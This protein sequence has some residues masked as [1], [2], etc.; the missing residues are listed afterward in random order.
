MR[1]CSIATTADLARVRVLVRR[2]A[3]HAP[4]CPVT[5]LYAEDADLPDV[6]GAEVL[7][8]DALGVESS[9][10]RRWRLTRDLPGF[11]E[12][13]K[14]R[15]LAR[16]LDAGGPLVL[17]DPARVPVGRVEAPGVPGLGLVPRLGEAV[18]LDGLEPSEASIV[19]AGV[20]DTGVVLAGPDAREGLDWWAS[21]VATDAA[22]PWLDLAPGLF[23]VTA[24]LLTP[25]GWD[26]SAARI[27]DRR[28]ERSGDAVHLAG[29]PVALLDLAGFDPARPWLLDARRTRDVRTLVSRDPVLREVLLEYA[30]ELDAAGEP[31]GTAAACSGVDDV[32]VDPVVQALA[33]DEVRAASKG[34]GSG[35]DLGDGGTPLRDWL[36]EPET[37]PGGMANL[38]RYLA[39]FYRRRPDLHFAYPGVRAGDVTG[40]LD[41]AELVGIDS[42]G[43]PRWV[44]EA[45]NRLIGRGDGAAPAPPSPVTL[46]PGVEVVG[47]LS[48]DLGIGQAAR[49]LVAGLEHAGVPVSTRTWT[50]T[51]SRLG[52]PWE[53]RAP[54][55]GTRH[56]TVV[57]C[58]NAD[59]LPTFLNEDAGPGFSEGRRVIGF[60]FWELDDFPP[61][62]RPALEPLDEIWVTS[63][64][65]ADVLRAATD[66][67]VHVLPLPVHSPERSDV[68]VPEL[69]D[70]EVFTF[71]FVF[72]YLSV[73]QRKNPLGLVAA[74]VE[75]FPEPG[76]ARLVIK[77]INRAMRPEHA[78][79]LAHVIAD[80]PDVVVI[81]RYLS[82]AELDALMWR[83]D[84][85]VS[86]HRSE[87]FGFTMA[88]EMAIGKPVIATG[89]SGNM[90][91][92]TPAN[93][94]PLKYTM[95]AV[96]PDADPY[97]EGSS[98]AEP[99][100]AHAVRVMR[101]IH[102]DGELRERLGAAA[103]ATIAE[104]HS[105]EALAAEAVRRLGDVDGTPADDPGQPASPRSWLRRARRSVG[106]DRG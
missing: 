73:F 89:Y 5:V 30:A 83:A 40:F 105:V 69:G 62:L 95:V 2:L 55:P 38:G 45:G 67:P 102:E 100:R 72:D 34:R 32:V 65:T 53:D 27:R 11:V 58:I 106:P 18:P 36:A 41:W 46:V 14:P 77:T 13:L 91:F 94:R 20:V 68:Q 90:E 12:T 52:V 26:V 64:F 22:T 39:E 10:L 25:A 37:G 93:S 70:S 24:A 50:R 76:A 28:L 15:L 6:E 56:D 61:G 42:D 88:E 84:C 99:R 29:K 101:R 75:A 19:R 17:L 74:F 33:V 71:L 82:R 59:M 57:L 48:A 92:M 35:L 66:K 78:E 9:E 54:Q 7:R 4:G 103:A 86:L 63:G 81:D 104:R 87:G 80:R 8:L 47:F 60:W 43:I 98:W 16:L 31:A 1:F 21:R 3:E 96:P 44:V 51:S 79:H 97:P 85:Y 49:M 23:P